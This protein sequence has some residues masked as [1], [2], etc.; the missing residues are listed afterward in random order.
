MLK[1]TWAAVAAVFLSSVLSAC[2]GGDADRPPALPGSVSSD[3]S[4]SIGEAPGGLMVGYYQEDAIN[5]PENP[6]PGTFYMN[7]PVGRGSYNGQMYYTYVGC[8]SENVGTISGDKDLNGNISGTWSGDVDGYAVG[9]PY[10]GHYNPLTGLYEGNYQNASGKLHITIEDCIEYHVAAYGSFK[11]FPV[12]VSWPASFRL[13][14][15]SNDR[16]AWTQPDH[17]ARVLV[18]VIDREAAVTN[19]PDAILYQDL[20]D[21]EVGNPADE[22][23]ASSFREPGRERIVVIVVL[24]GDDQLLAYSSAVVK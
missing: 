5:N 22:F 13:S 6:M 9:G 17:A 12:E 3:P 7:L 14:K 4:A 15:D 10:D 16:I 21:V 2:G 18:S 24:G 1:R 20:Q 8:Q 23:D 11:L 19:G